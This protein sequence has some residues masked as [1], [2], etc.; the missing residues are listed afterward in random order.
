MNTCLKVCVTYLLIEQIEKK[1]FFL[2]PKTRRKI[3]HVGD[4]VYSIILSLPAID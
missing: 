1:F 2:H 3:L 4:F